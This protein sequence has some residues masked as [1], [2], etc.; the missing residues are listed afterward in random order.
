MGSFQSR[1]NSALDRVY[2]HFPILAE[3]R[4]H[5]NLSHERITQSLKIR[6]HFL[7]SME[8][9]QWDELPGEV[10]LRGFLKRYAQFLGLD[11]D[12][13]LAPYL[14]QSESPRPSTEDVAH[15]VQQ[16][17]RSRMSL[18][19]VGLI[20]I[21]VFGLVN[22]IRKHHDKFESAPS[23]L[24]V[25]APSA[26]QTEMRPVDSLGLSQLEHQ[27]E[28]FSHFPLWMRIQSE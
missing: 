1:K 18:V 15:K 4:K 5:R 28:V 19:W 16:P 13:L 11:A 25:P 22:F 17:E 27:L 9:G 26:I 14:R 12:A 20:V 10:Y 23:V 7:A 21:F 6:P 2:T 24:E 3:R 8:K